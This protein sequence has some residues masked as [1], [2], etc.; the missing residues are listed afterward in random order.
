MNQLGHSRRMFLLPPPPLAAFHRSPLLS[1]LA[2]N[3]REKI[4]GE[5]SLKVVKNGSRIMNRGK[6]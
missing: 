5:N 4:R 2:T 6:I 3:E 1:D